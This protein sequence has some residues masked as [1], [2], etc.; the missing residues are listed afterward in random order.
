MGLFFAICTFV[1]LSISYTGTIWNIPLQARKIQ[2]AWKQ[3]SDSLN[4]SVGCDLHD[5]ICAVFRLRDS[6]EPRFSSFLALFMSSGL[7]KYWFGE[8]NIIYVI[9]V[10]PKYRFFKENKFV[11][12]NRRYKE[13]EIYS[14]YNPLLGGWYIQSSIT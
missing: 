2:Y 6:K 12:I 3:K 14:K 8:R 9:V 5:D 13:L 1:D 10:N 4:K 11:M 7:P